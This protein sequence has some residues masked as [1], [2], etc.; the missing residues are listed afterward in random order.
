MTEAEGE[1]FNAK[2]AELMARHG[3][4]AA[5]LAATGRSRD[6]V[7]VRVDPGRSALRPG[8]GA[9]AHVGSGPAALPNRPH[10]RPGHLHGPYLRVRERSGAGGAALHLAPAPGRARSAVRPA[11]TPGGSPRPPTA[12]PGWPA[13]RPRSTPAWTGPSGAPRSSSRPPP[14]A[15]PPRWSWRTA[16]TACSPSSTMRTRGCGPCGAG[17]CPG[18]AGPMV[19][20]PGTGPISGPAG[21]ATPRRCPG[22][23][24]AQ[25]ITPAVITAH[26]FRNVL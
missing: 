14:P 11:R 15:P 8:Q 21:S 7:T 9:P 10:Q 13:S 26:G 22:D 1:A 18:P 24:S 12:G 20:S 3:I 2:A 6:E 19:G 23:R 17:H 16:T 4:D 5:H 25:L